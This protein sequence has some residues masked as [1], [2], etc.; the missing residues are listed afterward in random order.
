MDRI[1]LI[2]ADDPEWDAWVESTPHDIYHTSGYHRVPTFAGDGTPQLIIYGTRK[3]FVA[4]PYLLQGIPNSAG[5]VGSPAHDVTSTYGYSGPLVRGCEPG[6]PLIHQAWDAFRRVWAEQHVVSVFTRFHPILANHRWF[7]DIA[8]T[9]DDGEARLGMVMTGETVSLDVTKPGAEIIA[10]YP[11]I[12]RQEI[13]QSR[14]RGLV[15]TVDTDLEHLA[16]FT[17]LYRETMER[18]HAQTVYFLEQDYFDNLIRELGDD[19]VLFVSRVGDEVAA[20]CLFLSHHGIL[21]PHLAGTST[22]YLPMSP[23]KVMWDDVRGWAAAR[24]DR[25]IHLGGGRGGTTDSLFAFKSRFS[26]DRHEFYTGRW[27]TDAQRYQRLAENSAG[28]EAGAA[29]FPIYRAPRTLE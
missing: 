12:M 24:G 17:A 9:P 6:D 2:E 15:T 4:W 28:M 25:V 29:Y 27:I 8:P 10:D 7:L 18:N 14:R 23:L 22:R 1:T 16:T 5:I 20:A 19:V 21:H 11:R 26:S 3:R 13:A